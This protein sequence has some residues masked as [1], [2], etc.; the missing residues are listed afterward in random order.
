MV[1]SKVRS[2]EQLGEG[3]GLVKVWVKVKVW[4][5]LGEGLIEIENG[6]GVG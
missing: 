4:L 2:G 3:S 5:E 1:R 6:L